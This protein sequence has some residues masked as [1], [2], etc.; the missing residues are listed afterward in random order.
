MEL[1]HHIQ[2]G[3]GAQPLVFVHGFCC[4]H[5]DW[6]AQMACFAPRYRCIAVD[7]PGHGASPGVPRA[8]TI[9]RFGA[10]I[11]D[12]LAA[13]ELRGAVLCGH[14][15][16]CRVVVEA[17]LQ[18]PERV[19][20]LILVDGSQFAPEMGQALRDLFARPEGFATVTGDW[21]R[22]M[23]TARSDPAVV[24]AALARA[25]RMDRA[26]GERLLLDLQR[27]D[28]TRLGASL[29]SLRIPVLALQSTWTNARRERASLREGQ[30]SPY[31]DMLRAGVP[32]LAVEIVP[33]C[34]HFPQ[35]DA[36]S[37]TNAA[38]GRFLASLAPA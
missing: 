37:A 32:E 4:D 27:Y 36:P 12:V 5:T 30:G 1:I 38:I 13:R 7:L 26:L 23:F 24:A 11:A 35:I 18:A 14:S 15:L 29:A 22:D 8:A 10:S 34:G 3:A 25:G 20:A 21:F 31:L 6:A 17:A 16:G 9:E 2:M 33:D 28:V 19:K